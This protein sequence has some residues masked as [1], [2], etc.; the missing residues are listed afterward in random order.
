MRNNEH[1]EELSVSSA[2]DLLDA[3][4]LRH[5][6]WNGEPGEWVFRGE[7]DARFRLVPT[8]ERDI[9]GAPA[10]HNWSYWR[11]PTTDKSF[12]SMLPFLAES[13]AV[14]AFWR[15]ADRGGLLVPGEFTSF[16]A[17]NLFVDSIADASSHT[18]VRSPAT[19]FPPHEH[20]DLWALA[21]HHGIPN[22]LLDWTLS[23]PIAAYFAVMHASRQPSVLG[24]QVVVWALRHTALDL[25]E[26][27]AELIA[28][29]YGSNRNLFAQRGVFTVVRGTRPIPPLDDLFRNGEFRPHLSDAS[30]TH[31][32]PALRRFVMPASESRSLLK[33]L[34]REGISAS[35]VFP[36]YDG[37]A[38]GAEE[39]RYLSLDPEDFNGDL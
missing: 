25:L 34:A 20:L 8:I 22:A 11:K 30:R 7:P 16:A 9:E 12:N 19:T 23:P 28:P 10:W 15:A 31:A 18:R 1:V 6:R 36:G 5:A 14:Q 4:C 13:A 33:M 37:A 3:L 26:R 29:A 2:G 32:K 27:K 21:R 35:T 24:T 38:R 39:M 17:F